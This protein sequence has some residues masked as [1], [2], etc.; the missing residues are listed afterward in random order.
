M[1]LLF[2][3]ILAFIVLAGLVFAIPAITPPLAWRINS[4]A[5]D[6]LLNGNKFVAFTLLRYLAW[7]GNGIALNNLGVAYDRSLGVDRDKEKAIQY[8]EYAAEKGVPAGR[9][10]WA[11]NSGIRYDTPPE[12]IERQFSF[13]RKNV[14]LGDPH[15]MVLLAQ[16]L[17]YPTRNADMTDRVALAT[18]L[19]KKAAA[20]G[21]VDY[22]Y[23]FAQHLA[24]KAITRQDSSLTAEAIRQYRFAYEMGDMRAAEALGT[25]TSLRSWNY[26]ESMEKLLGK[27]KIDWLLEAARHGSRTAQCK[28]M[29]DE[30]R[31]VYHASIGAPISDF[32]QV[33]VTGL[34]AMEREKLNVALEM[35]KLCAA[36]AGKKSVYKTA[37][38]IIGDVALYSRKRHGLI[39]PYNNEHADALLI[40]GSLHAAGVYMEEDASNAREYMEKV[41][42]GGMGS[43]FAS[44]IL[45]RWDSMQ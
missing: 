16:R 1:K 24:G 41:A 13:L 27:S 2:R 9:Y 15:S 19:F 39:R 14:V 43:E 23:I 31:W 33:M 36:A 26:P 5:A 44:K 34:N 21:D 20:T 37:A 11:L 4:Y 17:I 25:L 8:F 29:H 28:I 45:E 42:E 35:A 32:R 22:V 18:D 10:N 30:F 3:T 6:S 12:L 38:E 40:L 7:F